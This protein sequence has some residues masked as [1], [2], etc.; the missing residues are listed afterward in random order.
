MSKQFL[1]LLLF[2]FYFGVNLPMDFSILPQREPLSGDLLLCATGLR[3]PL[4]SCRVCQR[5]RPL[6]LSQK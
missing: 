6:L 3:A 4:K 2:L 5:G 1:L